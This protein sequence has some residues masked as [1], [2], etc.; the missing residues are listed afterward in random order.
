MMIVNSRPTKY[1]S[2]KQESAIAKELNWDTVS[3]SGA[4]PCTPGDVVGENWLGECK[5]HMT[6]AKS[7]YFNHDVWD[8]IKQEAMMKRRRPV[9]FTDDGSQS[10]SATWCVCLSNSIEI[11]NLIVRPLNVRV[12]TNIT[13]DHTEIVA[14]YK[15]I[16]RS[17]LDDERTNP[18]VYST[19]WNGDE[20]FVMLFES[21]KQIVEEQG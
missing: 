6:T 13:F 21:F 18:I 16:R 2:N 19:S 5:T 3:G 17:L 7:I 14:D 8:K 9:L 1:F 4:A 15:S 11:D 20:V 12:K 10:L